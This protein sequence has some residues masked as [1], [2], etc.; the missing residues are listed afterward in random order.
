MTLLAC[1][2]ITGCLTLAEVAACSLNAADRTLA[3]ATADLEALILQSTDDDVTKNL[4]ETHA[5]DG[6]VMAYLTP[7]GTLVLNEG[8]P[9]PSNI[10]PGA[11]AYLSGN[12]L[13]IIADTEPETGT[14]FYFQNLEDE[15]YT[16]LS[17]IN[18]QGTVFSR[19]YVGL[20][21]TAT[22]AP[23]TNTGYLI[24]DIDLDGLLI[25]A[26]KVG[27]AIH[28]Y[29]G[30][31]ANEV[32]RMDDDAT[33]GNTRLM[34]YDVDNGTLERVSVGGANSGGAGFKLLRIPN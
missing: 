7:I 19:C 25:Q 29:S 23:Y 11:E 21:G 18:D 13:K 6:T 9:L 17:V 4:L 32:A 31:Y 14:G 3:V 24:A 1:I 33:A 27:A 12:K 15:G 16:E 26:L 10:D 8:L 30:D 5:S 20:G 2:P 34:I 22:V 28:F